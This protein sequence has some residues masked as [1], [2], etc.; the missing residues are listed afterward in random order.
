M[1]RFLF[2]CRR[3]ICDFVRVTTDEHDELDDEDELEE[4]EVVEEF[5][6]TFLDH[7]V[8]ACSSLAAIAPNRPRGEK[9]DEDELE[10]SDDMDCTGPARGS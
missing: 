2:R 1:L 10:E 5:P 7:L 3:A 8:M 6:L 4:L 9:D